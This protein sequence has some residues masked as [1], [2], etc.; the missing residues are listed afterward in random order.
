MLNVTDGDRC[1]EA[2]RHFRSIIHGSHPLMRLLFALSRRALQ[3]SDGVGALLLSMFL[4]DLGHPIAHQNAAYLWRTLFNSTNAKIKNTNNNGGTIEER[5][6][7]SIKLGC[8][9]RPASYHINLALKV[10]DILAQRCHCRGSTPCRLPNR[11]CMA[12]DEQLA[13]CPSEIYATFCPDVPIDLEPEDKSTTVAEPNVCAFYY[14]RR[15]AASGVV[16]AMHAMSTDHEFGFSG[17]PKNASAALAWLATAAD[18][19]DPRGIYEMA[20]R[21]QQGFGMERNLT[22]AHELL[23]TLV[24]GEITAPRLDVLHQDGW[25]VTPDGRT[26]QLG[27]RHDS[28]LMPGGQD[29]ASYRSTRE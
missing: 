11:T 3:F 6:G 29:I 8:W 26:V 17:A 27:E 5:D 16:S 18:S 10:D 12:I 24:S 23:W 20:T 4:S 1:P 19:G 2:M 7:G 28:E 9:Q 25:I 22:N 14:Q 15:A 13:E 21:L